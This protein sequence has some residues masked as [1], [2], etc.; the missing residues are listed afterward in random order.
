V[1]CRRQQQQQN[2]Q[3]PLLLVGPE[4]LRRARLS[5]HPPGRLR[6]FKIMLEE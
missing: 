3:R 4:N 2:L 1:L 6:A 5:G